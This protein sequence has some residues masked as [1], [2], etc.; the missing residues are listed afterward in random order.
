VRDMAFATFLSAALLATLGTPTQA[1]P[2]CGAITPGA[3]RLE[4]VLDSMGVESRW[5]V[6]YSVDWLTGEADNS[7]RLKHPL[8]DTHCVDFVDAVAERLGIL[9]HFPAERMMNASIGNQTTWLHSEG[10]AN[11]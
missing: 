4:S 7:P 8:T 1:Q 9:M 3:T 5:L 2:C 10:P 11:G 6:G